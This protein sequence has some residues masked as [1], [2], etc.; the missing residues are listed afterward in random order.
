METQRPMEQ[1]ITWTPNKIWNNWQ[2]KHQHW[3]G[4]DGI[5]YIYDTYTWHLATTQTQTKP[6]G[7]ILIYLGPLNLWSNFS[8]YLKRSWVN[9]NHSSGYILPWKKQHQNSDGWG[10]LDYS[11][12]VLAC[13]FCFPLHEIAAMG[14]ERLRVQGD[15]FW[16]SDGHSWSWRGLERKQWK[17]ELQ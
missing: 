14:T 9:R 7:V 10:S 5:T 17:C 13:R 15:P 12:A 11:E 2:I 3:T 6:W 8:I 16:C 4:D 1:L